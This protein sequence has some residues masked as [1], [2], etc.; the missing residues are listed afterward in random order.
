MLCS[1]GGCVNC[2]GITFGDNGWTSPQLCVCVHMKM[3]AFSLYG[4]EGGGGEGRR[5][6]T[7]LIFVLSS[8]S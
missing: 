7:L 8:Y 1:R 3:K 2:V 4:G 6:D 5:G